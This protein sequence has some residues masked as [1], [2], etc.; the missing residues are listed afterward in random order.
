MSPIKNVIVAGV[1]H[2]SPTQPTQSL[3]PSKATGNLGPAV[4]SSLLASPS[5]FTISILTRSPST[6]VPAGVTAIQTDYTPSSLRLALHGQDAV[7]STI[8][9]LG[10]LTQIALIDAAVAAGVKRYIPSDYAPNTPTLGEM[11]EV[12]PELYMRLKPKIRVLEYLKEMAGK[13]E[14]FSWTGVGC[15]PL[16]DWVSLFIPSFAI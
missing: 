12:L 4:L 13:H 11:E 3:T 7:I 9:A 8:G 16:F 14:G 1:I 2:P 6:P 5:N 15:G 10:T